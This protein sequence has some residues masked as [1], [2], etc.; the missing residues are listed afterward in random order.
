[1]GPLIFQWRIQYFPQNNIGEF[2]LVLRIRKPFLLKIT[3]FINFMI[4]VFPVRYDSQNSGACLLVKRLLVTKVLLFVK[5]T[6]A[7]L[8]T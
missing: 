4:H 2:N 1:M 5:V 7:G 3:N 8:L 6:K